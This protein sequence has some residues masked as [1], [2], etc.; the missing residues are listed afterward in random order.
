MMNVTHIEKI[1]NINHLGIQ[2]DNNI[3]WDTHIQNIIKNR[4][5][6]YIYYGP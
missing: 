6:G 5:I 4:E 2:V 3:T 1:E